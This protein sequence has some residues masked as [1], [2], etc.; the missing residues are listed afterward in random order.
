M[1][2]HLLARRIKGKEPLIDYSQSHIVISFEYFDI[3]R[4][5]TMENVVVEEIKVCKRKDKEDRQA[6][7]VA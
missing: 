6:K 2:P 7:R 1:L 4:I 3:L 5:K